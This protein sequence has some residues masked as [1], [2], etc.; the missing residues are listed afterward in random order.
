MRLRAEESQGRLK[1][2]LCGVKQSGMDSEF[3]R[4]RIGLPLAPAR[5]TEVAGVRPLREDHDHDLR[6]VS[7]VPLERFPSGLDDPH[8]FGCLDHGSGVNRTSHIL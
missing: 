2:L 1:D 3:R 7:K 4:H 8:D 6:E 5:G